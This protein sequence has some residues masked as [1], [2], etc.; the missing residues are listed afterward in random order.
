MFGPNQTNIF[1]KTTGI[2]KKN[3]EKLNRL[4]IEENTKIK[5]QKKNQ[6]GLFILLTIKIYAQ[7][8]MYEF[9]TIVLS[10]R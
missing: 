7:E 1:Q 10:L 8:V 5:S 3:I 2:S 6:N 4:N 9:N